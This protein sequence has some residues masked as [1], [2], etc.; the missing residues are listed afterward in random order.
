RKDFDGA[1]ATIG[2][3]SF[4]GRRGFGILFW[5][6][7]GA[8]VRRGPRRAVGAVQPAAGW[9]DERWRIEAIVHR[10]YVGAAVARHAARPVVALGAARQ[11]GVVMVGDAACRVSV[12]EVERG[13]GAHRHRVGPFF[14][15]VR[16]AQAI[17]LFERAD[18]ATTGITHSDP[19]I[20]GFKGGA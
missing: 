15:S 20:G 10:P 1:I 5:A 4:D 3:I 8:W 13:N 9:I 19:A 6:H 2:D 14:V 18:F 17:E 7:V 16:V 12:D 11:N